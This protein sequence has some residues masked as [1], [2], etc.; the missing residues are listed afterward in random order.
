MSVLLLIPVMNGSLFLFCDRVLI[1]ALLQ[2]HGN[3]F[4]EDVIHN[5]AV[6]CNRTSGGGITEQRG[7]FQGNGIQEHV[8]NRCC[9]DK[10]KDSNPVESLPEV[11]FGFRRLI[12]ELTHVPLLLS[13]Q[14]EIHHCHD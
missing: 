3:Q 2:L 7:V 1:S 9:G 5:C 13:Q 8:V 6:H 10:H 12:V 11:K 14:E 4:T